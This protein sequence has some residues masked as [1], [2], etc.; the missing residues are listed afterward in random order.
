[1]LVVTPNTCLDVTTWL[2]TLTPGSVSRS[3]RSVITAGGKGVNVCRVLRLLGHRPVLVGLSSA[4]DSQ[5]ADLLAAEGCAFAPVAHAGPGRVA[6]IL[7]EDSGRITVV[8]GPG[9]ELSEADWAG[10]L[11]VVRR[12]MRST[13]IVSCSGSL[14][15]GV[16]VTAYADIVGIAARRGIL[17]L[18]D[19]APAVL[20][21]TLSSQ[22]YLV[23][24][25]LSE[26]EA[27]LDG[28]V[29][30]LVDEDGD[31]IQGRS[32][33]A[34]VRLRARGPKYAVVTAGRFGAALA[35]PESAE[36]IAAVPIT[37]VNPIGSGD[38]FIGGVAHALHRGA[39]VGAAVRFGM[40]VAAA[41]CETEQAGIFAPERLAELLRDAPADV[42][43]PG[44]VRT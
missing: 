8:N 37:P 9:P 14:P 21:A 24:P 33:R 19:A 30:E 38:S 4:D 15:P 20:A 25:N 16:P 29:D 42:A 2:A 34:A 40:T 5:L 41:A 7:M 43:E 39:A 35:G 17:S 13:D 36:W 26:A 6:Q 18:V 22:P 28:R 10:F 1:M 27:V 12:E 3:R 11:D 23:A 31:D 44:K 32:I